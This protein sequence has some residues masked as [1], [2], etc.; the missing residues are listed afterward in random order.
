MVLLFIITSVLHIHKPKNKPLILIMET[1]S[2]IFWR[3]SI[4]RKSQLWSLYVLIMAFLSCNTTEYVCRQHISFS[5]SHCAVLEC[6]EQCMYLL[7]DI[8]TSL[9]IQNIKN[10]CINFEGC[11]IGTDLQCFFISFLLMLILPISK[12]KKKKSAA[13]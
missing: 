9:N 5:V 8:E 1:G 12:K 6:C 13:L 7:T 2:R 10:N 3:C 11:F 4:T